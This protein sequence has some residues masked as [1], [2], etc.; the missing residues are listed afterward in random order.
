MTRWL[1]ILGVVFSLCVVGFN[2]CSGGFQTTEPLDLSTSS[3]QCKDQ[4]I[5]SAKPE[6][7]TLD[8]CENIANYHC[9]QRVFRP[10]VG[11][12][13]THE[14]VCTNLVDQGEAC[15]PVTFYRYDTQI[16]QQNAEPED[17]IEGGAYNRDEVV[18]FN[19]KMTKHNIS[20]VQAE[21]ASVSE[22]L[23]KN[24]ASCRQRSRP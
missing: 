15:V 5:A 13:L 19:T 9:D 24:L 1:F 21:G 16:Q 11:G 23:E 12:Q 14:H 17:L 8:L 3:V 7:F 18:C 4:V 10:G 22:A 20:L 6:L 2:N